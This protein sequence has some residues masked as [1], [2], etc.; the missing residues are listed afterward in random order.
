MIRRKVFS[1]VMIYFNKNKFKFQVEINLK[2]K[3]KLHRTF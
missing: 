2:I 3:S 1:D